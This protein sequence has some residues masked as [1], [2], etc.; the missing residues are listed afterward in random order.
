MPST[1][2]IVISQRDDNNQVSVT[3]N[4]VFE[5]QS[6]RHSTASIDVVNT[7][8]KFP[9]PITQETGVYIK[10]PILPVPPYGIVVVNDVAIPNP[11]TWEIGGIAP[12]FVPVFLPEPVVA[13]SGQGERYLAIKSTV[14]IPI[15]PMYYF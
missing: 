13:A 1:V 6:G 11:A 9:W 7:F 8:V 4:D 3:V 10:F 5:T 15:L 14:L 2:Q 12:G